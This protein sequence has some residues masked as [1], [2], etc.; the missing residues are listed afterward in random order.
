MVSDAKGNFFCP[1]PRA[2]VLPY[3]SREG[4]VGGFLFLPSKGVT[5]GILAFSTPSPSPHDCPL[6]NS[7]SVTQSWEKTAPVP[8]DFC[9]SLLRLSLTFPSPQPSI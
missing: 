8:A 7:G 9:F 1:Q 6:L 3:P 2:K 5:L 4:R